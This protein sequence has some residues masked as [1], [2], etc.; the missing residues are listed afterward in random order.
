M[1]HLTGYDLS[2]EDL[3]QFRQLGSRTPGHPEVHV[4][5]GAIVSDGSLVVDL[6][7]SLM[8]RFPCPSLSFFRY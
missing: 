4:T 8:Q 5:D 7:L 3:K 1:L 2:M 6:D